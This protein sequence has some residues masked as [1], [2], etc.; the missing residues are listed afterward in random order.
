MKT[1]SAYFTDDDKKRIVEAVSSAES[2]T[3]CEIVPV[4][5]TASGRY[6]RSEDIFGLIMSLI[7]V[8]VYWFYFQL[9]AVNE[10]SI[11]TVAQPPL[12][13]VLVLIVAGF[14]A[15][16]VLA[17]VFPVLRLPFIT[18]QEMEEEVERRAMETF[19]RQ[20]IRATKDSNG[21]LV[22]ISLYEHMVYVAGDDAVNEVVGEQDWQ[23]VANIV[24]A[25]MKR[26]NPADGIAEA[27]RKCG[28]I[29]KASFPC[30]DGDV[31][32]LNDGLVIL[33]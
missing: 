9:P 16:A 18:K 10:W 32:E 6:D 13:P 11:G 4:V 30:E 15:G 19:K 33:N 12:W 5:A 27:I 25:N 1:A 7:L 28:D 8:S 3:S 14:I 22:Y 23:Q 29:L 26:G 24:V 20:R 17:T 2:V 31:N 21:V